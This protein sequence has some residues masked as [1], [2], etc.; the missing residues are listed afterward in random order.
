[1][2]REAFGRGKSLVIATGGAAAHFA[3]E[4]LFDVIEPDL[5]LRGLLAFA[6]SR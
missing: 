2:K 5:V 3:A 4:S 6:Q 1:M